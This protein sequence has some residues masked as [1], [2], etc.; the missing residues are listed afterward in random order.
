MDLFT[1]FTYVIAVLVGGFIG[2]GLG[3][4]SKTANAYYDQIKARAEAAEA[5]LRELGQ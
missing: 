4:R 1:I 2:L 5:R 3:R